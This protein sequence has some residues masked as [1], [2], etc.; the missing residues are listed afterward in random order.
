MR[1]LLRPRPVLSQSALNDLGWL[2]PRRRLRRA[3][4][5]SRLA[6]HRLR[7]AHRRPRRAARCP[8]RTTTLT[9]LPFCC[10]HRTLADQLHLPTRRPCR[11]AA[12]AYASPLHCPHRR[13]AVA[14][15]N[16]QRA[17]LPTE[18][19]LRPICTAFGRA[20]AKMRRQ[21]VKPPALIP[22]REQDDRRRA[23][24]SPSRYVPA[25]PRSRPDLEVTNF[26]MLSGIGTG[27]GRWSCKGDLD[28]TEFGRRAAAWAA[29]NEQVS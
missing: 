17:E 5:R 23:T 1:P 13:F 21:G 15:A 9:D 25:L 18:L 22:A 14:P 27:E 29:V 8:R 3:R 10:A 26:C 11:P 24:S 16:A 20:Q 6:H 19:G 12:L 7:F 28:A 2:R 4:H